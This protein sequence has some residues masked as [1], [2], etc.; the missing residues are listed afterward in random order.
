MRKG[1]GLM[2]S[3]RSRNGARA[4][5]LTI[6]TLPS[7]TAEKRGPTKKQNTLR[8]SSTIALGFTEG[9]SADGGERS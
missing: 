1:S 6:M 5:D 9:Q 4:T 2:K 7:R 8:K 3:E